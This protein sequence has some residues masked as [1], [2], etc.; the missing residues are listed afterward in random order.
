M[1]NEELED[2]T[3]TLT[4]DLT[5]VADEE[6]EVECVTV[7]RDLNVGTTSRSLMT[8]QMKTTK[9]SWAEM[10]LSKRS[11]RLLRLPKSRRT[12]RMLKLTSLLCERV[13]QLLQQEMIMQVS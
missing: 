11:S 10:S 5:I 12:S 7:K 8:R 9:S 2:A 6:V 13:Q 1:A 3:I 4:I